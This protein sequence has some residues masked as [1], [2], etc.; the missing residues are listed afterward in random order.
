MRFREYFEYQRG[1]STKERLKV[2]KRVGVPKKEGFAY[3]IEGRVGVHRGSWEEGRGRVQEG[4]AVKGCSRGGW[5]FLLSMFDQPG[6]VL[7]G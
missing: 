6:T 4:G 1:W 2:P 3:Q 5:Y 7:L